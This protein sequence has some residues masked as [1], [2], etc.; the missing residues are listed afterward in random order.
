MAAVVGDEFHL[1]DAAG[2]G[3]L[4]NEDARLV[5][6]AEVEFV[7]GVVRS[8]RDETGCLGA[9]CAMSAETRET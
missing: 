2:F 6:A 9:L 5:V 3:N 8:A 4:G 1:I 7:H